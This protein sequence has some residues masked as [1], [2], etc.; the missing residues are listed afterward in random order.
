MKKILILGLALCT[1]SQINAAIIF[2]DLIG[3]AGPGLLGGNETGTPTSPGSGGEVGS[4][5]FFDD[6]SRL[7]T[8][9]VGWGSGKGFTDLSGNATASHLHGPTASVAPTA[10]NQNAGVKYGLD[11]L[12]G[13]NSSAI[14]GGF[15][16]TTTTI[17]AGDVSALL[18]GQ[19]YLNVHTAANGGGEIRGQLVTV[20]EPSTH[21]LVAGGLLG[22][23]FMRRRYTA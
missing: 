8:I 2:F 23:F 12:S 22:L 18:A 10:Y 16:S 6:V 17:L 1:V 15:T 3:R 21:V 20:P 13:F 4:G 7:I 11:G 9:N 14:N 5:I 19:F